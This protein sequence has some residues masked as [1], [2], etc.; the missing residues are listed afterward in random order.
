MKCAIVSNESIEYIQ[1]YC[2]DIE[3]YIQTVKDYGN[4]GAAEEAKNM[5]VN[6][7]I[8]STQV[9]HQIRHLLIAYETIFNAACDKSLPHLEHRRD[10]KEF[11]DNK[12]EGLSSST[13][14][15]IGC[16]PEAIK[17]LNSL[18]VIYRFDKPDGKY[19]ALVHGDFMLANEEK[20]SMSVEIEHYEKAD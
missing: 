9:F 3:G 12:A 1:E 4:S 6:K 11:L 7:V 14:F 19:H 16:I 10:I 5:L 15:P 13:A 20:V 18:N 17:L 8:Q 2:D